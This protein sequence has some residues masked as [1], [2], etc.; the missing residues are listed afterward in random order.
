MPNA[1]DVDHYILAVN[2]VV[3]S[4]YVD[5]LSKLLCN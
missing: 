1:Q 2:E 4:F 3:L 5:T